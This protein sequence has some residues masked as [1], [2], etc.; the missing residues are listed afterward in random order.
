MSNFSSTVLRNSAFGM[1]AQMLIKVLSFGFSILIVRQLGAETFGQYAAVTAFGSMFIFISD[2]GLSVYT[3]R[4]IA[5][6]R[7]AADGS[8]QVAS[9][10]GNILTLRVL[11]SVIAGLLMIVA[12]WFTGR[13]LIMIGAITLNAFGLVMYGVQ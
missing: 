12:A 13:P 4:E 10:Y 6:W 7:D 1:A 5:R 3:V 2:L 8:P 9:L 11:L